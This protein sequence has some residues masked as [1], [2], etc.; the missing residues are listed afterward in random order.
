MDCGAYE[1]LIRQI[2]GGSIP[3]NRMMITPV[4]L[5]RAPQLVP[6]F[7]HNLAVEAR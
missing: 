5:A 6:I 7:W 4:G 1:A 2:E 3:V